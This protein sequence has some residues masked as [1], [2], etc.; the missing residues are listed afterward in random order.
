MAS[1]LIRFLWSPFPDPFLLG[2]AS[3]LVP[4]LVTVPR[5]LLLGTDDLPCDSL[6]LV[7]VYRTTSLWYL[8]IPFD[9]LILATVPRTLLVGTYGISWTPSVEYLWPSPVIHF[10]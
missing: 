10:F 1:P 6:L 7:A 3:P 5:P 8:G 4:L 9:A 2:T